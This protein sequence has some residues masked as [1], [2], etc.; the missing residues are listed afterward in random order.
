MRSAPVTILLV[1]LGC[2][3][4][5]EQAPSHIASAPPPSSAAPAAPALSRERPVEPPRLSAREEERHAAIDRLL[6]GELSGAEKVCAERPPAEREACID[7]ILD[8]HGRKLE[9]AMARSLRALE[10]LAAYG[11]GR[12][13]HV[14]GT[15]AQ[16]DCS[17]AEGEKLLEELGEGCRGGTDDEQHACLARRVLERLGP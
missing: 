10:L 13:R 7:A 6:D 9:E 4:S 2:A 17:A 15:R 8:E 3:A 16:K 1:A 11:D 12:C 5:R 14:T